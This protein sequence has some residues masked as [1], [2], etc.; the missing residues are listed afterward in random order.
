MQHARAFAD[1]TQR[2]RDGLGRLALAIQ[3]RLPI[4]TL[5]IHPTTYAL[6]VSA[7]H[8]SVVDGPYVERPLI[9]TGAGDH[10]NSGFCAGKLLGFDNEASL[11]MGVSAS[12]FYVRSTQSPCLDDLVGML[13]HWPTR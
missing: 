7:G 13:R 8:I 2:T 12:G 6:A 1:T 5:V 10:F 11:L 9:T 3:N 4:S